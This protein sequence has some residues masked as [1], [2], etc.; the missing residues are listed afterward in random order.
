MNDDTPRRRF[1]DRAGPPVP[2]FPPV[3]AG[4][5]HAAPEWFDEEA[6]PVVRL[7]AM[8][9]G[10]ARPTSEAFDLIA[11]VHAE[12][13]DDLPLPASPEQAV[14]LGLCRNAPRS[15]ADIAADSDL[16]VGVV[17]VLLGDLLDAGLIG[18]SRPVPP[19][20]LPDAGILREVINGLRAL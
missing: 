19:A 8:T 18:V 7:Y 10:R 16:P 6:G 12:E 17:R 1:A 14:I 2:P 13:G 4:T 5:A 9:A 15:V 20:Q 11:V 3:H